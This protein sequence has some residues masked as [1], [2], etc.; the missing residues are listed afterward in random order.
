M[1]YYSGQAASY[2]ELLNVL[3]DA[4]VDQGWT[5]ADGILSKGG[6]FVRPYASTLTTSAQGPGL[7]VQGG[8]GKNGTTLINPS[9][10]Q[11]RIGSFGLNPTIP[12]P[13]FP[14]GYHVFIF[15]T[16]VFLIIKYSIERFF[17]IAFGLSII[18]AGLWLSGTLPL[19][20]LNNVG[21]QKS[22]NI[23]LTTAGETQSG[24]YPSS[25]GFFLQT[26][27]AT[28]VNATDA[29]YINGL[30]WCGGEGS[31]TI[32]HFSA[33][34]STQPLL[35]RL[36]SAWSL[37]T[38]L[39]A[40][41]PI[42]LLASSKR[43]IIADILNAR[44]LRINNYEPEQIITLGIDKWM[45]FPFHKKNAAVPNGGSNIDHTGTFGWAIRYDG[46]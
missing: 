46:P 44:Y 3:V 5:W 37:E 29:I 9:P 14:V 38:V 32:N 18:N 12:D 25:S 19:R 27:G 24:S 30:G 23:S 16:E 4:C 17:Y 31:T 2:Q 7:I 15:D 1:A 43:M 39:L 11:V 26:Y 45:V 6:A 35:S 42:M 21:G 36:P 20:Y 13:V 41:Q 33:L 40:I 28:S 8:T 34:Y 10:A 22:I